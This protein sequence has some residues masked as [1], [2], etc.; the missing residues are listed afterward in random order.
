MKY[1][2]KPHLP[3]V[4]SRGVIVSCDAEVESQNT[5]KSLGIDIIH[6]YKSDFLLEGISTHPDMTIMHLGE[7][8]FLC[9]PDS[10]EYYRYKLKYANL[11]CGNK[12]LGINYPNDIFYNITDLNGRIFAIQNQIE[13]VKTYIPSFREILFVNQGYTKCNICIVNDNAIITSDKGIYKVAKSNGIDVLLIDS[14][15]ILLKGMN[16]GF[17]GGATG[18]IAP[19]VLAVN[20]ELKNHP[21]GDRIISFCKNYG[22]NILSLKKGM[23]TDIGSILPVF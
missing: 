6:S 23:L 15:N 14:G 5:L 13:I 16:Y 22:V 12:N 21:N 7:N 20:G 8:N 18:L 4:C 19:D 10:Y 2:K 1:L 17:I 9:S 11:I 3:N